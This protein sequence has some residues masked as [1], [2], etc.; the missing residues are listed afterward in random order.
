MAKPG[1]LLPVYL[2]LDGMI[3]LRFRRSEWLAHITLAPWF[4]VENER[5]VLVD[6][7]RLARTIPAFSVTVRQQ[8]LFGPKQDVPVNVVADQAQFK[9]LH[10]KLLAFFKA[11]GATYDKQWADEQYI[12]HITRRDADY[13][14]PEGSELPVRCFYIVRLVAP[15]WCEVVER[16]RLKGELNETAA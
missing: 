1:A 4:A 7:H 3:G 12:A 10:Q 6:L 2:P 8:E 11:C 9:A 16:F 15:D 5:D 14:I 13:L